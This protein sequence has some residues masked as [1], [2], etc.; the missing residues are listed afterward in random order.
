MK[1]QAAAVYLNGLNDLKMGVR[2]SESSREVGDAAAIR[3]EHLPN[4]SL[5]RDC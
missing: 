3:T 5:G 4:I 2:S 1:P